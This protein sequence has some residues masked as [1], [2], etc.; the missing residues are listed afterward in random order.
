MS[1]GSTSIKLGISVEAFDVL[2]S[3]EM[4][5]DGVS[6]I[7]KIGYA[8]WIWGELLPESVCSVSIEVCGSD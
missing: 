8:V 3:S 4:A 7:W 2:P 1:S 5:G 6:L